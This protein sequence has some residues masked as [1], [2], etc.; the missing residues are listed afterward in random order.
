M[1][2][3]EIKTLV[4]L[5]ARVDVDAMHLEHEGFSLKMEKNRDNGQVVVDPK[6]ITTPVQD[7]V[8]AAGSDAAEEHLV[9]V[10]SPIVGTFYSAPN[11]K[12]DAFVAVGDRIREGQTLCIVEAMKLMNEIQSEVSGTIVA[13]LVDNAQPVEYGQNLFSVRPG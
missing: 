6:M 5:F 2:I 8:E 10:T 9:Y 3:N 4:E 7:S 13:C 11:P 1:D 12:A